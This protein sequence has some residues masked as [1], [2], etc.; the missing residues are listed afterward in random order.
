[1]NFL[2]IAE[3]Q[4]ESSPTLFCGKGQAQPMGISIDLF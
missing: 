3:Y 4:V 2:P 1:M